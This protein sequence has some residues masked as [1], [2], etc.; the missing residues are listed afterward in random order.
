MANKKDEETIKLK[1]NTLIIAIAVLIAISLALAGL[2]YYKNIKTSK[3]VETKEIGSIESVDVLITAIITK[4]CPICFDM[5]Q[6]VQEMKTVPFLNIKQSNVIDASSREA[7]ELIK[8]HNINKIPALIIQGD[9]GKLPL[10]G[11][12]DIKDGAILEDVPPPYVNIEKQKVIGLVNLTYLSDESCKECYDVKQHKDVL[13]IAFGIYIANEEEID[14]SS[15]KG[16][17]LVE[18]YEITKIPTVLMTSEAKDYPSIQMMWE[19]LGIVGEDGTHIFTG[20]D[21]TKD[22]VYKDLETNQIIN[23]REE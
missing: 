17:E 23:T 20:F 1:K 19:Q 7:K 13:E 11:F 22:I 18:K 12:R 8:T 15:E 16:K 14:I 10:K 21:M 4:K 6:V 9:T 5:A 3:K 2:Y